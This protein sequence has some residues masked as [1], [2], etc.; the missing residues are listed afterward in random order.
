MYQ[1]LHICNVYN[2]ERAL[3]PRKSFKE[4][5]D[6]F[7]LPEEEFKRRYRL[8]KTTAKYVISLIRDEIRSLTTR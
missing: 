6:H 3:G 2:V 7:R 8:S 1:Y 5:L 4:R